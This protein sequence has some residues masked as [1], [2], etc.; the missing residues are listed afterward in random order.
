MDT[1]EKKAEL[2][3]KLRD[4]LTEE[5]EDLTSWGPD[6]FLFKIPGVVDINAVLWKMDGLEKNLEGMMKENSYSLEEK[7]ED[8]SKSLKTQIEENS[9][10]LEEKME[11]NSR[12]LKL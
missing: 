2:Q 3:Q 7:M 9:R 6:K 11:E 8:N 1:G 5:G 12:S 10:N 4:A